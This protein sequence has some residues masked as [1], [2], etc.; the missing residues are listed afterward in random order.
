MLWD[1]LPVNLHNMGGPFAGSRMGLPPRPRMA[2]PSMETS[3][4]DICER[5]SQDQ[6]Q[7]VR[8]LGEVSFAR[9]GD[10][11]SM[12]AISERLCQIAS[13]ECCSDDELKRMLLQ[14]AGD[15][16]SV[17][18]S[19]WEGCKMVAPGVAVSDR[20]SKIRTMSNRLLDR[21]QSGLGRFICFTDFEVFGLD[22]VDCRGMTAS[23]GQVPVVFQVENVCLRRLIRR[24]KRGFVAIGHLAVLPP[25][26]PLH[27][28]GV[29]TRKGL[30]IVHLSCVGREHWFGRLSRGDRRGSCTKR[31]SRSDVHASGSLDE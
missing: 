4:M 29:V 7:A 9:L 30:T 31:T 25:F 19:L 3:G 12:S 18:R 13:V 11:Q 1:L 5:K 27:V 28:G 22:H 23:A 14:V 2:C 17:V 6:R 24:T 15:W 16:G 21:F 26:V 8:R 20:F 10:G